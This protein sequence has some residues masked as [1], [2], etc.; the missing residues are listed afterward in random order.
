M[1]VNGYSYSFKDTG[2]P[3]MF[4]LGGI[5]EDVA[6]AIRAGLRKSPAVTDLVVERISESREEVTG[7]DP[8]V[9]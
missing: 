2:N 5:S 8:V 7:P 6:K 3:A 9:V 4:V 1:A